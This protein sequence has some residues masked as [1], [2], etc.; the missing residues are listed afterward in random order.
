MSWRW[1]ERAQTEVGDGCLDTETKSGMWGYRPSESHVIA[2]PR[3][4]I[5]DHPRVLHHVNRGR[6]RH[7]HMIHILTLK[8]LAPTDRSPY[9]LFY[10]IIFSHTEY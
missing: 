5:P 6:A 10:Y 4:Q 9:Y 7:D 8:P 3:I 2:R 1:S